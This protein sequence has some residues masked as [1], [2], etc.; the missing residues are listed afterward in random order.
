[1]RGP[2]RL[3][4]AAAFLVELLAPPATPTRASNSYLVAA[5]AQGHSGDTIYL[6]GSGLSPRRH[7]YVMMA[8]PNWFDRTVAEYGNIKIQQD[9]PTTDAH[10]GF[11]AFPF[12]VLTLHHF[13]SAGCQIYTSDGANGYGPDFPATF[14]ILRPDDRG[15]PWIHRLY[16]RVKASPAR[17]HSGSVER[18]EI[19]TWA[20]ATASAVVSY[21]DGTVQRYTPNV[22]LQGVSNF[23][24]HVPTVHNGQV[25]TAEIQVLARIGAKAGTGKGGFTIVRQP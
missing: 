10:G 4:C 1:M 21:S 13:K 5:P 15:S 23:H 6:S 17:A 25:V 24:F 11:R 22:N 3:V 12:Q 7:L 9:G 16:V 2:F 14:L 19:H 8:C 20:G 18:V